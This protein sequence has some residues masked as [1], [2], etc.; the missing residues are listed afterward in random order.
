MQQH[1]ANL[2]Y[3]KHIDEQK[4]HFLKS[5]Y[6]ERICDDNVTKTELQLLDGQMIM[7]PFPVE[8]RNYGK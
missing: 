5:I 3:A 2:I 8:D 6:R 7:M 4:R 1:T